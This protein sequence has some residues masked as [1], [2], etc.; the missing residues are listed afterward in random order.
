MRVEFRRKFRQF[1]AGSHTSEVSDALMPARSSAYA[2][3]G[4]SQRVNHFLTIGRLPFGKVAGDKGWAQAGTLSRSREKRPSKGRLNRPFFF[5]RARRRAFSGG[6]VAGGSYRLT[7]EGHTIVVFLPW[8]NIHYLR[9]APAA[10]FFLRS[11]DHEWCA[12]APRARIECRCPKTPMRNFGATES[13]LSGTSVR[14]GGV[15]VVRDVSAI[16]LDDL[17]KP[18][19]LFGR[20][21]LRKP[22]KSCSK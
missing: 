4:P 8:D 5:C 16:S 6:S 13:Y 10:L 7:V 1:A 22:G 9:A 11:T 2:R 3:A 12:V 21:R 18:E 14:K 20:L 17:L 19:L 15:R